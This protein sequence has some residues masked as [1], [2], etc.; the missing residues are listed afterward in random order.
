[1]PRSRPTWFSLLERGCSNSACFCGGDLCIYFSCLSPLARSTSS[2][3]RMA[4]RDMAQNITGINQDFNRKV[5]V[6]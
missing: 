4:P 1:M 3:L 2:L 6:N 5:P